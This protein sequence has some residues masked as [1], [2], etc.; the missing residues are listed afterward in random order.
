VLR[1]AIA[2][3]IKSFNGLE[4]DA[5]KNLICSEGTTGAMYASCLALLN[6]GDE[7]IVPAPYYQYH[8]FTLQMVGAVPVTP[9][10]GP[11]PDWKFDASAIQ[12]TPARRQG[13]NHQHPNRILGKGA[14]APG[15][16]WA[17]VDNGLF[18]TDGIWIFH[19]GKSTSRQHRSMDG[20]AVI[21]PGYSN[22]SAAG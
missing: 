20:G 1:E 4:A 17:C 5:E 22:R 16:G 10:L 9:K 15:E 7:V 2:K 11:P 13:H 8:C 18:F 12:E 6:P 14:L 21:H 19:D 3:K